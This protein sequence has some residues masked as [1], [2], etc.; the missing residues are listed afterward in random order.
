MYCESPPP[1]FLSLFIFFIIIWAKILKS[2]LI[3]GHSN[4]SASILSLNHTQENPMFENAIS[5]NDL[6][7]E[8]EGD[9]SAAKI[10]LGKKYLFCL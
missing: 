2:I 7:I 8:V 10:A 6:K 4:K 9:N 5:Q 1:D 3:Q